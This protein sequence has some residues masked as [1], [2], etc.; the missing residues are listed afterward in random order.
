MASIAD[1]LWNDFNC[2][3]TSEGELDRD[4]LH[5]DLDRTVDPS[6]LQTAVT[7]G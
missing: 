6:D 1:V 5:A 4:K 2:R 7:T 3:R